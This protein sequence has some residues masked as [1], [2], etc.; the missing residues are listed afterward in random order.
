MMDIPEERR[1]LLNIL[2]PM[3]ENN[4]DV[5]EER[6]LPT[7]A[8]QAHAERSRRLRIREHLSDELGVVPRV[9]KASCRYFYW[10][11]LAAC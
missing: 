1:T 7:R 9:R 5:S 8:L 2:L 11:T 3:L 4:A 6:E 10:K